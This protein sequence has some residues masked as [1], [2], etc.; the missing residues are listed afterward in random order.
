MRIDRNRYTLIA[1][2]Q[3]GMMIHLLGHVGDRDGKNHAA[4]IA[5][6]LER[7]AEFSAYVRPSG[8]GLKMVG[9]L[10]RRKAHA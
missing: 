5:W 8:D 3:V 10:L 7:T 2:R 6:E 9:N 4:G 1:N